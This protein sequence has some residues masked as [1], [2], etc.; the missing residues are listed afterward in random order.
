M[1]QVANAP[2]RLERLVPLLKA[3]PDNLPLHRECIAL[4][5]QGGEYARALEIVD[6]RLTRHPTEAESLYA[7][8][9]ALIGLRRHEDALEILGRLEQQGVASI[10]MLQN[11]AT[12]HYVLERFENCRS[13]TDRL[14][15]AGDKSASTLH[16]AISSLHHLGEVDGAG[17]LA[18]ENAEV[19][20]SHGMLAG[21]SALLYQDL[22]QP[23]KAARL[24]RIALTQN[25]DSVDGLTVQATYAAAEMEIEQAERQFSRV[26]EIAPRS[27]RAW[28][29][30]GMVATLAQDFGAAKQRLSRA[31]MLMPAH[32]GSWHALGWAH[33]FSGDVAGA[34]NKFVHALDLDRNFGESHGAMAA[35]YAI[36]GDRAAAE[37]EIEVAERL[38]RTGLS[39]HFARAI[40]AGH[41][42]GA[43]AARKHILESVRAISARFGGRAGAVMN[44]VAGIANGSALK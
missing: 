23:Q 34:E 21:A 8:S 28:L 26:V 13:C 15:A 9:N 42:S 29:G 16:L 44:D 37:R 36:R 33:L 31:T 27:G 17:R 5:M 20:E 22:D 7:R 39:A 10:P 35:M 6:A 38:D 43:E 2:G 32:L 41:A 19:V 14:I 4:A 11:M 24:A 40:L 25:P 3:D 18:D 12:C 1:N 30:L